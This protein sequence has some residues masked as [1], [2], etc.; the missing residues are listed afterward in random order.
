MAV[1][2]LRPGEAYVRLWTG[3]SLVQEMACYLFGTKPLTEPI[4]AFYKFHQQEQICEKFDH[5]ENQCFWCI[6]NY[7]YEMSTITLKSQS[8]NDDLYNKLG[9]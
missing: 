6:W 4:P 7:V 8:V 3:S 1:N 9:Q 2:S 5:N